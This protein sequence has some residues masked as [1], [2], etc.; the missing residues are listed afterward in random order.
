MYSAYKDIKYLLKR[1]KKI[2]EGKSRN[3]KLLE[4]STRSSTLT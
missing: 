3:Y 4:G 1:K 2:R